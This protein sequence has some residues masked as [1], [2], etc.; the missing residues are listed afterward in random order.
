MAVDVG[1][2]T[3]YLDLDISGFLDGLRSAQSEASSSLNKIEALGNKVS[4]VGDKISSVGKT[5]T[6]TVTTPVVGLGTAIVKTSA[7]FES[8]MSKVSAISG[9]TGD[10]LDRLNQK[11]QEMGAKT[12]FSAKE[13]ADAFTYMAMAGWKTEDMIAGIDGIMSLAAADGLDLATTSDIVTDAL[14][15]FGMSASDSAHFADVLAKASSSANTNVSMLGESFKYVAPVA[16]SLGYSAE[17]TAIALGLMANAG[18][19]GSQGG[20]ALRSSLTKLINPTG[21]AAEL[22]SQYNLEM[23]NADGSMKSLGGVMDMLRNNLGGLTEAEQAQVAATIFGQEAMSGMLAIINASEADYNKLTDAIYNA[24][25]AA[26]EMADIQLDN[27]SGQITLL[28]SAL[29]GVAIQL[30]EILMPMVKN[31]VTGLQNLVQK[32]SELSP[33]QQEFIVKTALVAA[34]VGPVLLI[35]GKLTSGIGSL[36]TVVGQVAGKFGMFSSAASA[37]AGPATSAASGV[38]S[39][40]KSAMNLLAAGAGIMMASAG[41]ALLAVSAVQL[42][43]AGWPAVAVMGV[44]VAALVGLAAGAT[45]VAVPLTAGAAGLVAFGGAVTLVGVGVLAATAGV[46]LLAAQLPTIAEHGGAAAGALS[47]LGVGLTTFGTGAVVAGA[48]CLALGAGLV[49]AGTGAATAAV[50]VLALS[51][52]AVALS[53]AMA[54]TSVSVLSIESSAASASS[55]LRNMVT[56]VNVVESGLGGLKSAAD[57]AVNSFISTFSGSAGSAG[58]AA[59]SMATAASNGVKSGLQPIVPTTTNIMSEMNSAVSSGM[60]EVNSSIQSGFNSATS[61][62][63]GLAGQAFTWGADIIQG[64][65]RGIIANY[66]TLRSAVNGAA[67]IIHAN[68][69]FSVP[70]EGPLTDYESWMPDFMQGLAKGI[71]G[72]SHLVKS[73]MQDLAESMVLEPEANTEMFG[74]DT[75]LKSYNITLI[76]T[77]G[78]YRQLVE[79]MRLCSQYSLG[80]T[81]MDNGLNPTGQRSVE[82]VAQVEEKDTNKKDEGKKPDQLVIPITIG[83]EQIETVVVDLLRREVRT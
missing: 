41:L 77:I 33:Q 81:S 5:L 66:G 63:R 28:K 1:T 40:A 49:V 8:A 31:F 19:K 39:L 13:S 10:D 48:S 80:V 47:E 7:D 74:D 60:T 82:P 59:T 64:I 27:L 25:G 22:M 75:D 16:G 32:F 36:I 14:T 61:Y 6:T 23:T 67:S 71:D 18:I 37:A 73:S 55:S 70:D 43:E 54:A 57:S 52:A 30:G 78:L 4:G 53:A 76:D 17:D 44:L 50:G 56:A 69:H 20:T 12:K 26:Q 38:G 11:A 29:E 3:G 15:A 65:A 24:D 68:L 72:N 46:A 42:A 51:A 9:A 21:E 45:A 2:A 35:V 62:I 34:A 83:E 58:S 79:Q